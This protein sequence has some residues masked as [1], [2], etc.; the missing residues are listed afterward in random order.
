MKKLNIIFFYILFL[1]F[2]LKCAKEK[3][4]EVPEAPSNL[5]YSV[6]SKWLT[7]TWSDNSDNEECF[8]IERKSGNGKWEIKYQVN[9]NETIFKEHVS[10]TVPN[11][12]YR[13]IAWNKNGYSE[14]SNTVSV[15]TYDHAYLWVYLCPDVFSGCIVNY[16]VLNGNCREV[17]PS[18]VPGEWY[19]TGFVVSTNIDYAIQACEGCISNCGSAA[20]FTTPKTFFTTNYYPMIYFYCNTPCSPPEP[21][22]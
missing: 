16:F 1:V 12:S 22:E 18:A 14:P 9:A 7:L 17:N 20:A 19:N 5:S 10:W 15:P 8:Y 11:P 13:V 6:T 2:L 21:P 3:I 4:A